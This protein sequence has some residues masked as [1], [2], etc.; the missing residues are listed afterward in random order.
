MAV[1]PVLG[2]VCYAA[3]VL[4]VLD[5]RSPICE[6]TDLT[7]A[8]VVTYDIAVPIRYAGRV[9]GLCLRPAI[10]NFIVAQT[11]AWSSE[12]TGLLGAVCA[13]GESVLIRMQYEPSFHGE[14]RI[15][16]EDLGDP[17]VMRYLCDDLLRDRAMSSRPR[18]L[19]RR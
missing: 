12:V 15:A 2:C 19:L 11:G 9:R 4:V 16:P 8:R 18:P 13:L 6:V 14:E 5:P 10:R 3:V 1:A 7:V 17:T